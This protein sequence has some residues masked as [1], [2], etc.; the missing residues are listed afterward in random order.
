MAKG[1]ILEYIYLYQMQTLFNN[2]SKP[3]MSD[4]ITGKR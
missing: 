3:I 1:C 2:E 4:H